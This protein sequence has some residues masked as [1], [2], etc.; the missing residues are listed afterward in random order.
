MLDGN[1]NITRGTV[2]DRVVKGGRRGILWDN[3][4]YYCWACSH[5]STQPH[6]IGGICKQQL[7][8]QKG[9]Y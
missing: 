1:R 7:R 8:W 4:S 3:V 2:E 6:L 5:T 9:L